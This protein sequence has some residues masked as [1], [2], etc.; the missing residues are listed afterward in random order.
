[1]DGLLLAQHT[2]R[3]DDM[4]KRFKNSKH[5]VTKYNRKKS[6]FLSFE[7]ERLAHL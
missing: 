5:V 4:T 6:I 1:M 3:V 7:I 2:Y